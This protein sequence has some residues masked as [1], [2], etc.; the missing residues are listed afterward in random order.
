MIMVL[1]FF[2][3]WYTNGWRYL[4]KLISDRFL[5]LY[6]LFSFDLL[7]STLFSPYRQI[8][9]GRV[10]GSLEV[11]FRAF[12]DRLISRMIGAM[13]RTVV[14]ISGVLCLLIVAIFSVCELL[15]WAFLPIAPLIGLVL[16][17]VG[18]MPWR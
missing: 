14:L 4:L 1:T 13:I 2:S 7:V 11:Q 10:E 9:A 8:S 15:I 6:D 12:L 5:N 3:W 17:V 18:W 16:A